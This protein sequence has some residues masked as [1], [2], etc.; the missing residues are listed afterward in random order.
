[1]MI[2]EKNYVYWRHGILFVEDLTLSDLDSSARQSYFWQTLVCLQNYGLQR[3][4]K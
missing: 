3:H 2:S 4:I 1:M